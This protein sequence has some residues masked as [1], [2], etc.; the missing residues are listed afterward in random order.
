MRAAAVRWFAAALLTACAVWG[1]DKR[2][3][4]IGVVPIQD[5]QGRS[6]HFGAI[7]ARFA[8][9]LRGQGVEVTPLRFQPAAD[10]DHQ[11]REAHC[12]YVLYT[13]IVDIRKAGGAQF[14]K[15]VHGA[16]NPDAPRG[17]DI[18]EAEI[19]LRLFSM[20][21]AQPKLATSVTGRTDKK[22]SV[23][24]AAARAAAPSATIDVSD[25]N[26]LA[27]ETPAEETSRQRKYRSLAVANALQ[28]AAKLVRERVAKP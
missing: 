2:A 16:L 5:H 17:R 18:Y 3:V 13:D 22:K 25:T 12:D 4:R 19:E 8:G 26:P 20:D 21:E 24:V 28:N 10:V 6:L 23:P 1:A 14:V 27:G 15:A 9:L 7:D 11:A